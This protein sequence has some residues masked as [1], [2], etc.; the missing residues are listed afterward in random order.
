MDLPKDGRKYIPQKIQKLF[1]LA[2]LRE[3]I[4]LTTYKRINRIYYLKK[5]Y[6]GH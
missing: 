5:E 6:A 2:I 3:K 1:L 4:I